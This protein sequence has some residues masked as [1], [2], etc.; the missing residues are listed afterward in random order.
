[1]NSVK[2]IIDSY[3]NVKKN[4]YILSLNEE[5]ELNIFNVQENRFYKTTTNEVGINYNILFDNKK[6]YVELGDIEYLNPDIIDNKYFWKYLNEKFPLSSISLYPGCKNDDDVNKANLNSSIFS[7]SHIKIVNCLSEKENSNVLEIGPGYGNYFNFIT[8]KFP[9]SRYYAIDLNKLFYYDG[10]FECDG[11]NIPIEL[12]KIKFDLVFALN[13]FTH[14][15]KNQKVG[16]YK[17]VYNSLNKGGSFIFNNYLSYRQGDRIND[18]FSF[19]DKNGI[20][21]SNFFSQLIEVDEYD[22]LADLLNEIGFSIKVK[23]TQNMAI[24]ECK[25][26]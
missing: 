4:D 10:L 22:E 5:V 9:K 26:I 2:K 17:D 7:G 14:M 16:Y 20:F 19:K 23:L 12:K 6:E 18:F 3:Y 15:S 24:F 1:L 13:S 8:Q 11:K 25:K 21:Y